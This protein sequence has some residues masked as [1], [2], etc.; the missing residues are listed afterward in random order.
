MGVTTYIGKHEMTQRQ[1]PMSDFH[2][3]FHSSLLKILYIN[4]VPPV[5]QPGIDKLNEIRWI[6]RRK[7][8]RKQFFLD[9][10]R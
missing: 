4:P 8:N 6:G 7:V 1:G 10:P 3:N 2:D 5:S 9:W